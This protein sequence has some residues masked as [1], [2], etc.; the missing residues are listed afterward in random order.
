M[1]R[2][3]LTEEEFRNKVKTLVGDEYSILGKFKNTRTKILMRHN[4]CGSEFLVTPSH[5]LYDKRRCKACAIKRNAKLKKTSLLTKTT[6][7]FKKE[8]KE[9]FG[10]KLSVIGEYKRSKT[11]IKMHCNICGNNFEKY[12]DY[13]LQN[14]GCPYC[15][16]QHSIEKRK[17]T[18]KRQT[19]IKY[20]DLFEKNGYTL[21]TDSIENNKQHILLLHNSCGTKFYTRPDNFLNGHRCPHCK[22]LDGRS[23]EEKDIFDYIH[24]LDTS[25]IS[26]KVF[27]INK[28]CYEADI[29]IEKKKIIIEYDGL[30]WHSNKFK[31]PSFHREK[32]EAFNSIGYRVINVFEDEWEFKENIVKEKLA[33]ILESYN[34]KVIY[35]R[36]CNIK[37]ISS[38]DRNR[39]LNLHHI[40]G[41]D[42]AI[43]SLGL[44]YQEELI[45]VM[46][47]CLYR[48]SL[49]FKKNQAGFYELSR[50]ATKYSI[51]GGFSKL[52]SYAIKNYN[53][54]EVLTYADLRWTDKNNN[55][56]IKNGFKLDHTTK[57]DYSYIEST[58]LRVNRFKYRKS[59][60]KKLYPK[61]YNDSLSEYDL[62]KK[63]K[64][65]RIYDCGELVYRLKR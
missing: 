51:P 44:Y 62:S 45:G 12:P 36:K 38:L 10:D 15:S 21:L 13:L 30:Y 23:N 61:I 60:I 22:F 53:I 55:V 14:E 42:K 34:D 33:Y 52:L 18:K 24:S 48:R 57:E 28:K 65:K 9:I 35:A 1:A 43:I 59:E 46:S 49:G 17:E 7:Q 58:G 3:C 31:T 27:T 20:K 5:F 54:K 25:A 64:L 50:Y 11:K 32:M 63:I 4:K 26:N 39:F 8:I 37:E 19:F 56:Y 2:Q 16:K 47:F 40:Q 6:D 29:V 41:A